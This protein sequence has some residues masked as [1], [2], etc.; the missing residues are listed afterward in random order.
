MVDYKKPDYV[1]LFSHKS[2]CV[3]QISSVRQLDRDVHVRG[4][5]KLCKKTLKFH[6]KHQSG[7]ILN[8]HHMCGEILVAK[9]STH[10]NMRI[11]F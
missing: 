5:L 7:V 8:E 1:F 3:H 10:T 9:Y 2:A 4:V 6:S 11:K